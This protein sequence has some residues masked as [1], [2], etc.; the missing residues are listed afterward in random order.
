AEM[1]NTW[2][3]TAETAS[4]GAEALDKLAG[5]SPDVIVTDLH[6][7]GIDGYTLLRRLQEAGDGPPAIVLT[8]FAN[9]ET[10]VKALKELGAYWFLEKPVQATALQMLLRRAAE[11]NRLNTANR[12]LQR[13]LGYNGALG[14]LVGRSPKMQE[15]FGL[16]Q[17][18]APTSAGVLISGE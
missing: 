18:A 2:G 4:G 5:F 1:V 7:A 17:V 6:M 12:N 11:Q 8:A 16:L 10:P 3:M 13:Q 15:I 14:E 9:I